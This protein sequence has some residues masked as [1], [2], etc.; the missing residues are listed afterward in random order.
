MKITK[1]KLNRRKANRSVVLVRNYLKDRGL[2]VGAQKDIFSNGCDIEA[3]NGDRCFRIEVKSARLSSRRWV[4]DKI[5][6]PLKND[7]IAVVYPSGKITFESAEDHA[8]L[9]AP[10]GSRSITSLKSIVDNIL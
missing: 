3:W 8:R 2:D 7:I 9:C 5:Q 10:C 1:E 4:V 6:S